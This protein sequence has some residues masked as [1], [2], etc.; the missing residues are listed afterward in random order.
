MG[1]R[2]RARELVLQALYESE[3]SDRPALQVVD[4]QI[5]RRGPSDEGA[6]RARDLFLKTMEKRDEIDRI[7]RSFLEHWDFER[8]SLID[9]NI[10]RF[11]LAE[12]LYFPDVPSSVIIDE[13]IEI[14]HRYSSEEAGRF[15]N[16]LVDRF[17]KEFRRD[18]A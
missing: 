16:G 2:R 15:V 11:A 9:R 14:A 1:K 3:F 7:I 10:L 8:L 12:V 18:G 6:D 13:A 5:E 17:V 4:Q